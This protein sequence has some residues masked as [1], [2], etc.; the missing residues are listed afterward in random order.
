MESEEIGQNV[1]SRQQKDQN[2]NSEKDEFISELK[3][4]VED[5]KEQLKIEKNTVERLQVRLD[6]GSMT[7]SPVKKSQQAFSESQFGFT[8]D[9]NLD[10]SLAPKQYVVRTSTGD[11]LRSEQE[12]NTISSLGEDLKGVQGFN[13]QTSNLGISI[14]DKLVEV[15]EDTNELESQI[16]ILNLEVEEAKRRE[17]KLYDQ[18][19]EQRLQIQELN[20]KNIEFLKVSDQTP[21]LDQQTSKIVEE[22]KTEIHKRPNDL[23]AFRIHRTDTFKNSVS[24]NLPFYSLLFFYFPATTIICNLTNSQL[25]SSKRSKM[26][27]ISTP[28]LVK[29][30]DW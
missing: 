25:S 6:Y 2:K 13:A 24:N 28:L 26:F 16:K 3:N 30:L 9:I 1:E 10:G 17:I 19:D 18:I 21:T 7:Q 11:I 8:S 29:N 12:G 22:E 4:Q 23:N 14:N 5:L 20:L 15:Q 27:Q